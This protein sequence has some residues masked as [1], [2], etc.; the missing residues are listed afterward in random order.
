MWLLY[1]GR[2]GVLG[3]TGVDTE[4]GGERAAEILMS[5]VHNKEAVTK[6]SRGLL[7]NADDGYGC[8]ISDRLR[9]DDDYVPVKS[10]GDGDDDDGDYDYAPAA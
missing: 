6:R 8:R 1:T 4:Y 2:S 10:E 3:W 5:V 9:G 7:V